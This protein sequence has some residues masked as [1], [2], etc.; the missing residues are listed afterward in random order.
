MQCPNATWGTIRCEL[1]TARRASVAV[2]V[3]FDSQI[4]GAMGSWLVAAVVLACYLGADL[5]RFGPAA[6]GT[7]GR[8]GPAVRGT[9]RPWSACV[10][11]RTPTVSPEVVA[12]GHGNRSASASPPWGSGLVVCLRSGSGRRQGGLRLRADDDAD[13]QGGFAVDHRSITIARTCDCGPSSVTVMPVQWCRPTRLRAVA[14]SCA[15]STSGVV[16]SGR[17]RS[18]PARCCVTGLGATRTPRYTGRR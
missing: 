7:D 9:I 1:W 17:S 11:P 8:G 4:A 3:R 13:G 2:Y 6:G 12:R 18:V 16:S 10:R 5:L 14:P 15:V